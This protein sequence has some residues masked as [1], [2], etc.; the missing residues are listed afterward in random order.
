MPN[1]KN[2]FAFFSLEPSP[3]IDEAML[4]EKYY[5]NMRAWHPDLHTLKSP[6]EQER[7]LELSTYNNRAFQTLIDPDKRLAYL[8]QLHGRELE[9]SGQQLPPDFL[10]EMMEW[11]EELA[12]LEMQ[13]DA[14][15]L[16]AFRQMLTQREQALLEEAKPHMQSYQFDQADEALLDALQNFFFKRK[17]L[18]RI[19]EKLSTFAPPSEND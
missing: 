7:M 3:L 10:M 5:A 9:G 17:Y 1:N 18:L 19:K 13:P 6:E 15:R 11:N 12:E 16:S 2:Y 8:L 14:Q 4:K